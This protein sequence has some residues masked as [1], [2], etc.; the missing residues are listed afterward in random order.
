MRM[1]ESWAAHAPAPAP[2]AAAAAP[3]APAAPAGG[4]KAA[5]GFVKK[6]GSKKGGFG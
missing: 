6:A 5:G 4:K 3:A 2:A 1:L